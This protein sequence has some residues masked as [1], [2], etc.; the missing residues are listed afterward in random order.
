MFEYG[1][2]DFMNQVLTRKLRK[3]VIPK[4]VMSIHSEEQLY[5]NAPTDSFWEPGNYKKTT[6]RIEDG[7]KLCNDMISLIQERCVIEKTYAKNLQN[8]SQKWHDIITAGPEYGTTEAAWKAT[9]SEGD[10][11]SHLH[12]QIRDKLNDDV[13]QEIKQWQKDKYHKT[14]INIKEKK[15][16]DDEFKRVQKP[17]AKLFDRVNKAKNDYHAVSKN[18]RTLTIQERN[19]ICDSSI[20]P[21]QV[22]KIQDRVVKAKED[23]AKSKENYET[24]LKDINQLNPIYKQEMIQV[25]NKC[26]SL[27][28]KRLNFI[29]D[30]L[31]KLH[32]CLDISCEPELPR[33]YEEFRHTIQNADSSKDIKWWADTYGIGMSMNWPQFEPFSEE[34]RE[35]IKDQKAKKTHTTN[36]GIT[37][38]NQHRFSEELPEV[39]NSS[40]NERISNSI[41]KTSSN[42]VSN[43]DNNRSQEQGDTTFDEPD[44]KWER[45]TD[46]NS[47]DNLTE[48]VLVKALYDYKGAESDELSF[49]EGDV[50]E[51]LDEEDEQGWCT[52]RKDNRTGLYP[53]EYAQVIVADKT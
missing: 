53:A 7:F 26:Q 3:S 50:F 43:N 39:Q 21:D 8:W 19:A 4:N 14:M 40:L 23:V 47:Y 9:L 13:I 29:K 5:N 48:G 24:C 45:S 34:F 25:F 44:E 32:G 27:E 31:F 52:G 38:I 15:N 17:W 42:N 35:I 16:I 46:D 41:I 12:L 10:K 51:K 28:E 20:S 22:R 30:I 33:I 2:R 18:E 37:L 11:L 49:K 36:D 1:F 6:K